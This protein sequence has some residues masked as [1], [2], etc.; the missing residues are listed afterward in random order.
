MKREILD[1]ML[2]ESDGVL[3]TR[4]AVDAGISKTYLMEYVKKMNLERVAKGVYLEPDAWADYFYLLQRRYPQ[5]I[6]SHETALYLLGMAEREPLQFAVTVRAG[7][8]AESMKEQNV[9]L[10]YTKKELFEVGITEVETPA[11][12]KVKTYNPERTV[13]DLLRSRSNIEIQDVQSALKE[14]TRSKEK[15][16]PLLMRYA[17]QFRVERTL[18]QYLE[19]LL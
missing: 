13:C 3:L 10:Y 16:I 5:T 2:R 12:H 8:H 14:Y 6:F 7:Y 1:E 4:D 17:K 11:G 18:R 15:N 19:V 9:K